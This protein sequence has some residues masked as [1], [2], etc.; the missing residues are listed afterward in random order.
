MTSIKLLHTYSTQ[1]SADSIEWCPIANLSNFF[2]CGTY[3]LEE[4]TGDTG[5]VS[6]VYNK[7]KGQILLF[8]FDFATESYEL[9]QQ[10]DMDAVLD[11]KWHHDKPYLAVATSSGDCAVFHLD[12]GKL[13]Q[14]AKLKISE[15][16]LALALDWNKAGDKLLVSTSKGGATI[17]NF[18]VNSLSLECS[19]RAHG[20]EAWTCAFDRWNPSVVYTGLR[21]LP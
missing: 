19:W 8:H 7:K 9:K 3:H 20:F 4:V 6:S 16:L 17:L 5:A 13:V 18:N 11:Q 10:I 14:L 1:Y 12:D 2:V 15:G 21:I